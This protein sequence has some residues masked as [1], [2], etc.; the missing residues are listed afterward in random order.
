M[1]ISNP[2]EAYNLA[3][4][5]WAENQSAHGAEKSAQLLQLC[6]TAFM[7][8]DFGKFMAN[9]V[10]F[11]YANKDLLSVSAREKAADFV[12][13]VTRI[14]GGYGLSSDGLGDKIAARLRD[15]DS[16]GEP[17][18]HSLQVLWPDGFVNPPNSG[19][20]ITPPVTAAI[21]EKIK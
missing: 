7:G 13:G 14:W 12:D 6:T 17:D 20:F 11:T 4:I 5:L 1:T 10:G 8:H 21:G 18:L 16:L 2:Q 9:Y 15:D 19:A 3:M